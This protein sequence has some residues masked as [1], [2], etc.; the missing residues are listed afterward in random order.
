MQ[1]VKTIDAFITWFF[2]YCHDTMQLIG[3][4]KLPHIFPKKVHVSVEMLVE[5]IV[6]LECKL[7]YSNTEKPSMAC[8]YPLGSCQPAGVGWG[9]SL[10]RA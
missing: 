6:T 7:G 1:A 10:C 4:I 8:G 5:K 3:F 9:R 2:S